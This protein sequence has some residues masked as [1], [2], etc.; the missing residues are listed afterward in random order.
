MGIHASGWP[1]TGRKSRG[2]TPMTVCVSASSPDSWIVRP[3][4]PG[5]APKTRTQRA[6]ERM[7]TSF[8]PGSPS[9]AVKSRPRAGAT[10]STR[11]WFGHTRLASSSSGSPSPTS[12]RLHPEIP[13]SDAS[14]GMDSRLSRTIPLLKLTSGQTATSPPGSWY[15]RSF[16]STVLTTENVA[17]DAPIPSARVSTAIAVKSGER[18]SVRAAQRRSCILVPIPSS[19][20]SCVGAGRRRSSAACPRTSATPRIQT[21]ALSPAERVLES[22]RSNSSSMSGPKRRRKRPGSSPRRTR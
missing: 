15:G 4:T 19:S 22:R 7:T 14:A 21:H 11:K 6:W 18:P 10:P 20:R 12:V 17:V 2:I 9:S 13:V 3:I 5:S 1:T 8:R 16:K